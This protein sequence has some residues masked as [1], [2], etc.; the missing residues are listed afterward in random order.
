MK[1]VSPAFI[2]CTRLKSS[3]SMEMDSLLTISNYICGKDVEQQLRIRIPVDVP[4]E[5]GAA[6]IPLSSSIFTKLLLCR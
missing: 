1:M 5:L 3:V 4:I 6:H 2:S